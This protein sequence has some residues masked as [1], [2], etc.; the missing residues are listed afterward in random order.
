MAGKGAL[1]ISE[2]LTKKEKE[3]LDEWIKAQADTLALRRGLIPEKQQR[4]DSARLL[5]VLVKAVAGGNLEDITAPE[6]DGVNRFLASLA[7]SRAN[8][9][10]SPSETATFIFSL[11]N[12]VFKFLQEE[13]SD[14]PEVLLKAAIDFSALV[15]KLGL[16][17][18]ETY[19][20][21]REEVIREQQK[22]M[23]ELS[24]PVIQIWDEILVS[25]LIGTIDSARARQFM[26]NLLES[27]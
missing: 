26:E 17:T 20:K 24:T 2:L 22:S 11:K 7:A 9:G 21:G 12:I 15:D 8:Q 16:I 3:I 14:R 5:G 6:Y 1:N 25:P 27:I 19:V 10:F 18:F 4:E 23:L 13:Y